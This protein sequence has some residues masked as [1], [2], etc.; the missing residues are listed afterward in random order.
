MSGAISPTEMHEAKVDY[1]IREV[2]LAV[3]YYVEANF[4]VKHYLN[5]AYDVQNQSSSLLDTEIP[6][7]TG[8]SQR[9][10]VTFSEMVGSRDIE[11]EQGGKDKY[12]ETLDEE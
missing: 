9:K 7:N 6:V 12:E 11:I 3:P 1:K 5:R 4:A 10:R 2:K 8:A